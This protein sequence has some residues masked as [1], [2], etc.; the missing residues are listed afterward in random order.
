MS[1]GSSE[2]TMHLS[3]LQ[4]IIRLRGGTSK[5]GNSVGLRMLLEILDLTHAANFRTSPMYTVADASQPSS[6]EQ[7]PAP[8]THGG[9][10]GEL[11]QG[12]LDDI[13]NFILS[14]PELAETG[15]QMPGGAQLGQKVTRNT[16]DDDVGQWYRCLSDA[17]ERVEDIA[18]AHC[19]RLAADVHLLTCSPAAPHPMRGHAQT[20]ELL[21]A[22]AGLLDAVWDDVSPTLHTR[23]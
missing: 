8:Q 17:A 6:T 7:T 20:E 18:L 22:L 1:Q 15:E 2:A 16:F 10:C 11:D 21:Q 14:I 5:I 23:V 4:Q 3:G 19:C 9:G 12:M 13:S